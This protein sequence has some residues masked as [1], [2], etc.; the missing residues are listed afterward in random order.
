[1]KISKKEDFHVPILIIG[2]TRPELISKQVDLLRKLKPRK[3]YFYIDGPRN[4]KEADL[5]L[6]TQLEFEKIDW[7]STITKK[8]NLNRSG[9]AS[10]ITN[11]ISWAFSF[12][13]NLIILEDDVLPCLEFFE[14][15]EYYLNQDLISH[16]VGIISGHQ[17]NF[18]NFG[19]TLSSQLSIYPRIHGWATQRKIWIGFDYKRKMSSKE[20]MYLTMKISNLNP[21]FFIYLC[22]VY[23]RIFI[24][25]LDTWDYQFLYYLKLNNFNCIV[26]TANLIVNLGYGEHA[27]NTKITGIP[28]IMS[29][30]GLP[31]NLKR[32][33]ELEISKSGDKQ[34]RTF[35]IKTLLKSLFQKLA[36]I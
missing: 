18:Q 12:E 2:Y 23:G 17:V 30:S 20:F 15:C 10:S 6:R 32:I 34:W 11:A 1:V 13:T 29:G 14:F 7:D 33:Q 16:Q 19:T 27:T 4:K 28:Q 24:K 36:K 35:R 25:K 31:L 3:I 21:V 9:A 22:Y 5:M 26:P 8:I